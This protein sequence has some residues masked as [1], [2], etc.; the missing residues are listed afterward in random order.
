ME[1]MKMYIKTID[2]GNSWTHV[3]H[4]N[5]P[6]FIHFLNERQAY[7]VT[8]DNKGHLS[9]NVSND[10]GIHWRS[11]II[12]FSYDWAKVKMFNDSTGYIYG[13]T[14]YGEYSNY[15]SLVLKTTNNGG[16]DK[17]R[18]GDLETTFIYPNPVVSELTIHNSDILFD[19]PILVSVLNLLGEVVLKE[20]VT[21]SGEVASF[22]V[23]PL[24]KGIYFLQ[25]ESAS[26]KTVKKFVKE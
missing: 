5:A 8:F 10:G 1:V 16:M 9:Y 17:R 15:A 7:S 6:D 25:M 2:H 13:Q 26:G 22:N 11:L 23:K 24:A 19:E 12:P 21:W 18:D 20:E 4:Y 3:V 14:R